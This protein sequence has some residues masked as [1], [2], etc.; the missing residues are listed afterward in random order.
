T[1]GT[2]IRESC[3]NMKSLE[4]VKIVATFVMVDR[5]EKGKGEKSAISEVEEEFGFPVYS[6]VDVYDIIE[7]LEEKPENLENVERIKRYLAVNGA[8]V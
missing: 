8:K 4:G 6:V 2:A 3:E 7:Y 5:K 1:A